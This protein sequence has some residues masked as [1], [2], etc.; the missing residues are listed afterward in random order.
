VRYTGIEGAPARLRQGES[1]VQ[2]LEIVLDEATR[3]LHAV[4][5]VTSRLPFERGG[6]GNSSLYRGEGE[7][8]VYL[9]G[10]RTLEYSGGPATIE[11]PDARISAAR[12]VLRLAEDGRRVQRLDA[13]SDRR[14]PQTASVHTRQSED[15]QSLS[16]SLV[17]EAD[18]DRYTLRGSP[19]VLRTRDGKGTCTQVTAAVGYFVGTAEATFPDAENPGKTE[20][21][22]VPCSRPL[23]R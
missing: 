13:A 10:A 18:L 23:S 4:G 17:Y 5:R 21:T 1:D 7:R 15:R 11:T 22:T 14:D 2:G 3:D 8:M 20:T 12:I 16:D 19:L 6:T 9:D